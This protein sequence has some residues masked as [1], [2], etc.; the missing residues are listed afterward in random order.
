MVA[1]PG[2][3][4]SAM[5]GRRDRAAPG[6]PRVIV[7]AGRDRVPAVGDHLQVEPVKR[8]RLGQVVGRASRPT[9]A[10]EPSPGCQTVAGLPSSV[11]DAVA[12]RSPGSRPEE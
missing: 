4:L 9:W 10:A 6:C 2:T 5:G 12:W 3:V 8:L 7:M 11:A 1:A